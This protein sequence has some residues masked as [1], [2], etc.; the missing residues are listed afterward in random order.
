MK[1]FV[2]YV[3][4]SVLLLSAVACGTAK[5]SSDAPN[6]VGEQGG[7]LNTEDAQENAQ[8]ATNGVRQKQIESDNRAIEQRNNAA[9]ETQEMTDNDISSLVRNKLE[10]ALPTSQLAVESQEGAVTVSGKVASAEDISKVETLAKE[11][12]GV[13]SVNVT[14][15]VGNP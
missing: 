12:Q 10:T 15:T 14:A 3:L 4:S 6:E 2:P 5:T 8:D 7:Q 9:G 1:K 13:K 11:V